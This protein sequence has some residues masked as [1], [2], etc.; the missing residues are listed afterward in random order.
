MTGRRR[1]TTIAVL[2][3]I[4]ITAAAAA[5]HAGGGGGGHCSPGEGDGGVIELSEACF[6]PATLQVN[7]GDTI[8]FVNR[9]QY[10]HNVIGSGWGRHEDIE[11]GERFSTSF[12]DE[13]IYPFACTLHPG[14][15][16]VILVGETQAS[17]MARAEHPITR[18][19]S[20]PGGGNDWL[21]PGTIGL[22][23]GWTVG[24]GTMIA[25]RRTTTSAA[26]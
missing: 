18:S 11:R 24:V 21:A 6:R 3:M 9:D 17:E 25:R 10:A 22:L 13:G 5:A 4:G 26:G 1:F 16:G 2:A 20:G 19:T 15:T 7:P 12:Q 8:T 23:V 14:M